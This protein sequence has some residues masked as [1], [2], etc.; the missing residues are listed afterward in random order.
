MNEN[1][2]ETILSE[3]AVLHRSLGSAAKYNKPGT[4]ERSAHLLLGQIISQGP[5]GVKALAEEF[6][7]DISTVSRQAAALEKKGYVYRIP[8]PLDK[9]AYSLQITELGMK[10][11]MNHKQKRL[12]DLEELLND[13]SAEDCEAFGQ[14]LKKFNHTLL[15][16]SDK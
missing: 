2:L 8:D 6:Q 14:L 1:W 13:W 10:E 15:N 9:R 12:A 3:L 11:L 16:S 4:I 7:L 5:A